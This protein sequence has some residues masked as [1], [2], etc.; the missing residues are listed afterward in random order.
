MEGY[1][2]VK[3]TQVRTNEVRHSAKRREPYVKMKKRELSKKPWW[4]RLR[5]F[6]YGLGRLR[7]NR[8]LIAN[9]WIEKRNDGRL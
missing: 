4:R 3:L 7:D 1:S 5:F 2:I 6:E 9:Q 8:N